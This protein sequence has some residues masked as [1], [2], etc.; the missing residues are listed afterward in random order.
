[1]SSKFLEWVSLIFAVLSI[2][3]LLWSLGDDMVLLV[4]IPCGIIAVMADH[5][6][7]KV[8]CKEFQER[9]RMGRT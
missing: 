6:G 9:N 4:A 3:L 7:W 5:Y 2:A 1:M 8:G